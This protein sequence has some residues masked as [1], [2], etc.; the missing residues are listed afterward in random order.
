[1]KL[2]KWSY[3]LIGLVLCYFGRVVFIPLFGSIFLAVL[4]EPFVAWL[5]ARR[6]SR[7]GST[8][9]VVALFITST[10]ATLWVLFLA[11]ASLWTEIHDFEAR[12]KNILQTW[13]GLTHRFTT[14]VPSFGNFNS[15]WSQYFFR[16]VGSIF[17][18]GV[19]AIF[20]PLLLFYLLYDKENLLESFHIIIGRS[21]YIPKLNSELPKMIRSFFFANLATGLVLIVLHSV[22]FFF[23]G[24]ENWLSIGTITGILNLTPLLGAPIGLAIAIAFGIYSSTDAFFILLV[25][26]LLMV[27]HF[28][29]NN[30]LL[31]QMLGSRININPGA[32]IFGLLFWGWIW[33]PLGFLLGIP[34][35]AL[36]KII[37]ESNPETYAASN[38][39]AAKPRHI[40]Y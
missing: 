37:L 5:V 9:V 3:Y 11:L 40:Y 34:M 35:T 14:S 32:L 38:L 39:L 7:H 21:I 33:G 22:G 30:W 36:I 4:L 1:M 17:E 20:V 24:F 31:P 28:I 26:L 12:L 8:V 16:G 2:P 15:N 13:E 29:S 18:M 23:L 27:A 10:A 6:L 25:A 19:I